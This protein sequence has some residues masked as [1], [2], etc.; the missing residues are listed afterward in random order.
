MKEALEEWAAS[1]FSYRK[2]V[3]KEPYEVEHRQ[4]LRLRYKERIE[5]IFCCNKLVP[6]KGARGDII[7]TLN[8]K[9]NIERLFEHWREFCESGMRIYFVN[10]N[11]P[12]QK[13]AI[14]PHIHDMVCEKSTLKRSL[15]SM[16]EQVPFV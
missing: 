1:Y 10:P 9:E 5:E 16:A 7:V 15:K 11:L 2:A 14:T 6:Q 3:L 4:G 12:N 13:W 8:S